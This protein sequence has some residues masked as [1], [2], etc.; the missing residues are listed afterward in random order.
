MYSDIRVGDTFHSHT[1][2]SKAIV[3]KI[4]GDGFEYYYEYDD[5]RTIYTMGIKIILDSVK[6][7]GVTH[8]R[9]VDNSFDEDLFIL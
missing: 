2:T 7:G 8:N 9:P 6:Q 3:I 1:S 5:N 4:I